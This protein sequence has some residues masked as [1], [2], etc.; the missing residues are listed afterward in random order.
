MLVCLQTLSIGDAYTAASICFEVWGHGSSLRNFSWEKSFRFS[1]KNFDFIRKNFRR[2]F[3][4]RQLKNLSFITKTS[5]YAYT[6]IRAKLFLFFLENNH[7]PTYFK[8]KIRYSIFPDPSTSPCDHH[9][10]QQKIWGFAT[11]ISPNSRIDAPDVIRMNLSRPILKCSA[12]CW[13]YTSIIQNIHV[14]TLPE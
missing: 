3:F 14:V 5:I 12:K 6:Y 13:R 9:D 11:P 4:S 8:S 10:P 7:F 2:P 1:P